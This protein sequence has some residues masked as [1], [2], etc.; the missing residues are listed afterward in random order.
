[1]LAAVRSY[2]ENAE[3]LSVGGAAKAI[4]QAEGK[5][6]GG[7]TCVSALAAL[8]KLKTVPQAQACA[9]TY[10]FGA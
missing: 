6:V 1:M 9:K 2:T 5:N 10:L 7:G 4:A 8:R 3:A